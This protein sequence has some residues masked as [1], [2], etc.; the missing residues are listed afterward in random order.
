[1]IMYPFRITFFFKS[2]SLYELLCCMHSRLK[3]KT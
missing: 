2:F 1:M 3:R